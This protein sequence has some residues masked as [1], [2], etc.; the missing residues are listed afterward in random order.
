MP[1]EPVPSTSFL[2]CRSHGLLCALAL[3]HVREIMRAQ[4]LEALPEMPPCMLGLALIRGAAVPV[5]D[6]ARLLGGAGVAPG[7]R[8]VAL[9]LGRGRLALAV[10]SVLGVRALDAAAL[11]QVP[12][13][14][15]GA[16]AG[17]VAAVAT[18]DAE[19]MLVLQAGRL[20]S[21]AVWQACAARQAAA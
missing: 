1:N 8:F 15:Q 6:L 16:D 21:D 4:P 2:L 20:V 17:M 3:P 19:L 10:D 11:G 12:P 5:L 14:L 7:G 9:A 18:L 13:L